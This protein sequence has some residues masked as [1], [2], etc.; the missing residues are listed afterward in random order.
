LPTPVEM[1]IFSCSGPLVTLYMASITDCVLSVSPTGVYA[2][3]CALFHEAHCA[4]QAVRGFFSSS[5]MSASIA[6][7]Q[8]PSTAYVGCTTRPICERSISKCTIPPLPSR[9]AARAA[10]AYLP[11]TPVVRSSK[12]EPTARMRSAFWI[13]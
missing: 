5:G 3:G 1:T 4:C 13:A 7:W 8:S 12:R 2:N 6:S 11:S 10:G 9:S